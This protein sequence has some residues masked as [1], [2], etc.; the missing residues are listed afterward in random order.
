MKD[1]EFRLTPG[2]CL[3]N[4]IA[5]MS[6]QGSSICFIAENPGDQ[7]LRER[8]KKAFV[9]YLEYIARRPDCPSE[10]KKSPSV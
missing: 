5:V 6:Q 1:Y 7:L 9:N 2:Y 8:I 3:Y 4:G 10:Y